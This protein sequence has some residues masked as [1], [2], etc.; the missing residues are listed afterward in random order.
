MNHQIQFLMMEIRD[1]DN[2]KNMN[3]NYKQAGVDIEAGEEVVRRIKPLIKR[4]YRKMYF[5]I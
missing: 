1:L 2:Y 4:T 5:L 3:T